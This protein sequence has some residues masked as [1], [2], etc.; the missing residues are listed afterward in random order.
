MTYFGEKNTTPCGICSVCV[1]LNSNLVK[2]E[3]ILISEN[4][5]KLLK[6]GSMDSREI[7]EKLTFTEINILKVLRLLVDSGKVG[8]N[9]KNQYYLV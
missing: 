3:A 5:L 8:I 2:K 6:E 4:I 9:I 7:S 1:E